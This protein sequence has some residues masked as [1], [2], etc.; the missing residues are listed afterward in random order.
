EKSISR[1]KSSF[2]SCERI[3]DNTK[4]A[5]AIEDDSGTDNE[6]KRRISMS[7]PRLLRPPLCCP[8]FV[9]S[10]SPRN[11]SIFSTSQPY[12]DRLTRGKLHRVIS[13]YF[14]G[15]LVYVSQLAGF[16]SRHAQY[17]RACRAS[18]VWDAHAGIGF[19]SRN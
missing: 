4:G 14:F 12:K 11:V 15:F 3:G 5:G 10:L 6:I 2:R 8:Q 17:R 19:G 16:C 13:K 18:R 9:H 7:V 1:R